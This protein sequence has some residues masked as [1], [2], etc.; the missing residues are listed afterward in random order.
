VLLAQAD[1][2][3]A[4]QPFSGGIPRQTD[5]AARR[6]SLPESLRGSSPYRRDV[7]CLCEY[8]VSASVRIVASSGPPDEAAASQKNKTRLGGGSSAQISTIDKMIA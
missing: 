6:A 2:Q 4:K 5:N 1:R 7:A 3:A 8:Q